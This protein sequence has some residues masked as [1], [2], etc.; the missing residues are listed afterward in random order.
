[1]NRR[2]LLKGA[3]SLAVAAA[4]PKSTSLAAELPVEAA[5]VPM[6]AEE[7]AMGLAVRIYGWDAAGNLVSEVVDIIGESGT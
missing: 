3:A 2:G 4:L 5:V 6:T 1:M 7:A